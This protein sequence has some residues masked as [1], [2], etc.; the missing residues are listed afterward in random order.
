MLLTSRPPLKFFGGEAYLKNSWRFGE[1]TIKLY[2]KAKECVLVVATE[3][4]IVATKT[5][6]SVITCTC[7]Q[8]ETKIF[9]WTSSELHVFNTETDKFES[10][11][12]HVYMPIT[13]LS[14]NGIET[15]L[16]SENFITSS[17]RKRYQ[18]SALHSVDFESLVGKELDIGVNSKIL[19]TKTIDT[20]EPILIY[21]VVDIGQ[22]YHY[23][24]AQGN[25]GTVYL[26]YNE[27]TKHTQISFDGTYYEHLPV[28]S[29]IMGLPQ[30]T[31]D[32]SHVVAFTAGGLAWCKLF[33]SSV[34]DFVG[35]FAWEEIAQEDIDDQ[36][37]LPA[38]DDKPIGH[39]LSREEYVYVRK[40][41]KLTSIGTK[42]RLYARWFDE[43]GNIC[44]GISTFDRLDDAVITCSVSRPSVN[45]RNYMYVTILARTIDTMQNAY[46]FLVFTEIGQFQTEH[47][48]VLKRLNSQVGGGL[49]GK[50]FEMSLSFRRNDIRLYWINESTRDGVVYLA[51]SIKFEDDTSLTDYVVAHKF[52]GEAIAAFGM[53]WEA[54]DDAGWFKISST[55]SSYCGT[56]NGVDFITDNYSY[57]SAAEDTWPTL[58][59][60]DTTIKNGDC[61]NIKTVAYTSGISSVSIN[62]KGNIHKVT[63]NTS[64]EYANIELV[65]EQIM[66]YDYVI[67]KPYSLYKDEYL[68]LDEYNHIY[69]FQIKPYNVSIVPD[70]APIFVGDKVKLV[71]YADTLSLS[72]DIQTNRWIYPDAPADWKQGNPWPASWLTDIYP[73]PYE[74][75]PIR[76]QLPTGPVRF[77]GTI[78]K[79]TQIRP[80]F[81]N[82][83]DVWLNING[84]LW[85]SKRTN[86]SVLELDEYIGTHSDRTP[87]INRAV[88]THHNTLNEHYFSFVSNRKHLLEVTQTKYREDTKDF[89]LYLPKRNEQA[90]DERITN[91]H[92]IADNILSVFTER[93][94]WNIT[95]LTLDDGS[96]AYSAPVLSKM[97]VGCREYDDVI[98]AL[99]GQAVLLATPRG[100]AALAPQDFVATTDNTITYLSDTIQDIYYHF[101]AD[102]VPHYLDKSGYAPHIKMLTYRYWLMLYRNMDRIILL[103]DT[104]TGIWWKW[105]TP[106]PIK[107][108]INAG[109]LQVMM[110]V[111]FSNDESLGGVSYV[112]KDHDNIQYTGVIEDE[113][114]PLGSIKSR[115]GYQDDIV[116]GTIN[117]SSVEVKDNEFVEPRMIKEYASPIINWH[118]MSQKLHFNQL[119]NYKAIKGITV[120]LEGDDKLQAIISTKIY[121]SLYHPEQNDIM[122]IPVNEVKTFVHRLN[123]MHAINF[124]YKFEND[125]TQENQMPLRLGA[126]SIKY[127]V[128]EGIR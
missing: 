6:S 7:I 117:G 2:E 29:N 124:Q 104:R 86:L 57:F 13:S 51:F 103:L 48:Y 9:I 18:Y 115:T 42:I 74:W 60:V 119:N 62:R 32:A 75:L 5:W 121:R 107:S 17:Y 81:M 46:L 91:L 50:A 55:P 37:G 116:E 27:I 14:I 53:G 126:I 59:N 106:Y 4:K 58:E 73:P 102:K 94:I 96:A 25:E 63:V 33:A 31:R 39:F 97:P 110:Q 68:S 19:Y 16:E 28:L 30:L 89:L 76:N 112:L 3:N 61:V 113:F 123:L 98:T 64:G 80:L 125:K 118:F 128:K 43:N 99:D 108:I 47:S 23:D 40:N 56:G 82:G 67:W 101:Y 34:D 11:A 90:F 114:K 69:L 45:M 78:S 24:I 127:E 49:K 15:S 87:V 111:D 21:P 88:P 36:V 44:T 70:P 93:A 85:T 65:D 10:G 38:E 8:I 105:S 92:P 77:E 71:A 41:K 79:D 83:S 95:A 12:E 109:C 72:A 122:E 120:V 35:T 100:I 66:Y 84:K 26:R 52:T 22:T 20:P 1:Y 54:G